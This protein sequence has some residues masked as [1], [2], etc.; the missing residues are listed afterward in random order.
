MQSLGWL[1]PTKSRYLFIH[2]NYLEYAVQTRILWWWRNLTYIC[3]RKLHPTRDKQKL[4]SPC[5]C[6]EFQVIS[7]PNPRNSSGSINGTTQKSWERPIGRAIVMANWP[8]YRTFCVI[9]WVYLRQIVPLITLSITTA[10]ENWITTIWL[11][12]VEPFL[13]IKERSFMKLGFFGE[14]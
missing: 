1:V 14:E 10:N 13:W 6:R 9:E 11:F 5:K 7:S 2:S 3:F 4:S 12:W 8:S